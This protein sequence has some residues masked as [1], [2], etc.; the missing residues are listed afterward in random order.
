M[1]SHVKSAGFVGSKPWASSAVAS[2]VTARSAATYAG[3]GY[4]RCHLPV[5]ML[6]LTSA[7]FNGKMAKVSR[8]WR[9]SADAS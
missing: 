5:Q 7:L 8:S 3:R 9:T 1:P 2:L 4:C 6:G